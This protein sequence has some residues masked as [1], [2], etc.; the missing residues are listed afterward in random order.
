MRT[1]IG[2]GWLLV[3]LALPAEAQDVPGSVSGFDRAVL[4]SMVRV[5]DSL[6][7]ARQFPAAESAYAAILAVDSN[8]LAGLLGVVR[9]AMHNPTTAR[10][11]REVLSKLERANRSAPD[12]P[13]LLAAYGSA[14]L[15]WRFELYTE[16]ESVLLARAHWFLHRALSLDPKRT[17]VHL[18]LY[19]CCLAQARYP[20]ADSQLRWLAM[21]R[22]FPQPVLDF[23]YD[24]LVGLDTGAVLFTNGDLDMFPV[25]LLQTAD[26]LR[27]DVI[28]VNIALLGAPWYVKYLKHQRRLPVSFADDRIDTLG[29]QYVR[30][31]GKTLTPA[32]RVLKN[33]VD[34]RNRIRGGCYFASTVDKTVMA[35]FKSQLSLEGFVYR[36]TNQPQLIPVNRKRSLQNLTTVYRI[37]DFTVD[38]RPRATPVLSG[39]ECLADNCAAGYLALADDL[40]KSREIQAAIPFLRS[41]CKLLA[42]AGRPTTLRRV[43]DYWLK[44]TPENIEALKLQR[45][46]R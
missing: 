23:A 21:R 37:P 18:D 9:A 35:L 16:P 17:E 10:G 12:N 44:I 4:R 27:R 14:L 1:A 32:M 34:Q 11:Y 8:S 43:V 24:L 26:S 33:I 46:F 36:L 5:A 29:H 6:L 28:V 38:R 45:E 19:L 25:L 15:P 22:F 42:A 2:R 39:Y 3:L 30:R 40:V 31:W 20:Q 7:M 13:A 41:A